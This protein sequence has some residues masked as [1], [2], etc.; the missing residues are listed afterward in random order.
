MVFPLVHDLR[1]KNGNKMTSQH[2]IFPVT[3]IT[4]TPGVWILP[5]DNQNCK[6][7]NNQPTQEYHLNKVNARGEVEASLAKIEE[8]ILQ[9]VNRK[10][11][12]PVINWSCVVCNYSYIAESQTRAYIYTACI[13]RSTSLNDY[14]RHV[15]FNEPINVA[16]C[17]SMILGS[18]RL[19]HQTNPN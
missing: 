1:K 18:R 17:Q 2:R 6:A 19:I 7:N 9:Q 5:Y 3:L 11:Y 16:S 13:V 8:R 14:A 15:T 10:T 4:S 12:V